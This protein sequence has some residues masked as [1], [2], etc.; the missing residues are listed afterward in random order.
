MMSGN[1][2][3]NAFRVLAKKPMV[4]LLL[5]PIHALSPLLLLLLPL[6]NQ[7]EPISD[8]AIVAIVMSVVLLAFLLTVLYALA[9]SVLLVS[10]A[11]EL[12]RDGTAG[13]E[14]PDGWFLRGVKKHWWKRG[15]LGCAEYSISMLLS[16]AMQFVMMVPMA[17]MMIPITGAAGSGSVGLMITIMVLLYVLMFLISIVSALVMFVVESLSAYLLA[18]FADR[19]FV[20]SFK[21]VFGKT[22]RKKFYKLLGGRFV[23]SLVA[24]ILVAFVAFGGF[25]AAFLA[26]ADFQWDKMGSFASEQPYSYGEDYSY[27]LEDPFEAFSYKDILPTA[28]IVTVCWLLYSVMEIYRFAYEF[29]VFQ[30]VKNK[31]A[32]ATLP[33]TI[34]PEPAAVENS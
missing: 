28:I 30:E 31:E 6:L 33:P 19:D 12:L 14:T 3:L 27:E 24:T 13:A 25:F 20:S 29:C 9:R 32:A 2:F 22:G 21:A 4:L 1:S 15:V 8:D 26:Q 7:M 5:F 16:F 11:M 10:P 17:F 23:I 34:D 18:A